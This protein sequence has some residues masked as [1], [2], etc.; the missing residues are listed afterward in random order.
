MR[1]SSEKEFSAT[2]EMAVEKTWTDP[3]GNF[4]LHEPKWLCLLATEMANGKSAARW[5]PAAIH[6]RIANRG[7]AKQWLSALAE[8]YASRSRSS[9]SKSSKFAKGEASRQAPIKLELK[10][11]Q[12]RD[13]SNCG[14]F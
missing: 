8:T 7:A 6:R 9:I 10:L 11:L 13:H 5:W 1:T 3:T 4:A 2:W 14:R 12:N